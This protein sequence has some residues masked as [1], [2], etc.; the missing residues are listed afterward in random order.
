MLYA[1]PGTK[2]GASKSSVSYSAGSTTG[3][4]TSASESFKVANSLSF[5]VKGSVASAGASFDYSH[6]TTNNQSLSITKSAT[7]A[8]SETGPATDGI[9]P[10]EDEIWLLLNPTINLAP[11]PGAATWALAN[12]QSPDKSPVQS[13][14][15]GWLNG[16][17]TMPD[18]V[19]K[20]LKAA[21]ITAQEYPTI[22]ARDPLNAG[23]VNLDPSRF[24]PLNITFPYEPPLQPGDPV[25]TMSTTLSSSD[26]STQ[27]STVQDSYKIGITLSGGPNFLGIAGATLKDTQSWEWTNS[28]SQSFTSGSNQSASVTIAGPAYGYTGSTVIEVFL[29]T[30][31]NTFAFSL[32]QP[33]SQE[34]AISGT[35]NTSAGK[36]IVSA[37]VT[38]TEKG[39]RHKTFTNGKGEFHFYGR[40]YGPAA[41]E[42]NGVKKTL[43]QAHKQRTV[44]IK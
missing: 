40:L 14:K 24:V 13:L 43:V 1:P 6:S 21:G 36:A 22:L 18:G 7:S 27:G 20:N 32:V 42:A 26:S 11:A 16:H 12:I 5:E 41:V 30:I 17:Y 8:I 10:D 34:A 29:D 38:L 2:G 9:N 44:V 33:N 4:T 25:T 28:T 39:V 19:A 15:V 23:S 37:P 3:T 31:Y 35:V